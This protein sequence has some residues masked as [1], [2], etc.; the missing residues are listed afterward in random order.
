[1]EKRK[2]VRGRSGYWQKASTKPRRHMS[3]PYLPFQG[4]NRVPI[5]WYF[6]DGGRDGRR[7]GCRA[8]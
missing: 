5:R 8:T 1:M 2:R 6:A 3:V 4:R 7:G